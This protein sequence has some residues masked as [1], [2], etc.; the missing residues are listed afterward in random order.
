MDVTEQVIAVPKISSPARPPLRAVLPATHL[1]EQLVEVPVLQSVIRA[2]GRDAAG[3]DWCH[4]AAWRGGLL[5]DDGHTPR[6]VGP[7]EGFT[8]SPG[9]NTNTGQERRAD[10]PVMM[11]LEFQQSF[12]TEEMPQVP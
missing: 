12:E 1:V 4:V 6:H 9:R 8:A 7:P 2:R 11:Q 10:D 5:V 3:V